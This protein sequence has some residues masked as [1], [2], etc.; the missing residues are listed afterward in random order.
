MDNPNNKAG[1]PISD[2]VSDEDLLSLAEAA[3]LTPYSQEYISLLARKG[4]LRAW[5]KG[6][7]W[8]TSKLAV[9]EYLN[10]QAQ[11]AKQE[12]LRKAKFEQ[13]SSK[14]QV[15]I[16][17]QAV[18]SLSKDLINP[19]DKSTGPKISEI[20]KPS[21]SEQAVNE[22]ASKI[23]ELSTTLRPLLDQ[24]LLGP[25]PE[26][27]QP[28]KETII[29]KD[30][31]LVTPEPRS[32]VKLVELKHRPW[33][34]Y[35]LAGVIL[36]VVLGTITGGIAN[37][38]PARLLASLK[39][40]WTIDG[41]RAGTAANEVLILNEAGNISIKG[42][43][44]TGG[45][46]RS[47][48]RDGIMP[49]VVDSTTKVENLNA[50]TVDGFSSEQFTLAF[51][52]KNGAVTT[53]DVQL[54]GDVEV[55]GNLEVK[56]AVKLTDALLVDGGLGVWGDAIFHD[57]LAVEGGVK[58]GQ[59]LEVAGPLAA[60]GGIDTQNKDISLGT[61]T[62]HTENRSVVENLNA[63][64]LQ[65][66]SLA[67]MTLDLV[68]DNGAITDNA[69][70]I[71]GLNVSGAS[72]F[73]GPATFTSAAQFAG[74]LTSLGFTQLLGPTVLGNIQQLTV[75]G[76]TN[77]HDTSI[78]G[79]L[80]VSGTGIFNSVGVSGLIG[81]NTLSSQQLSVAHDETFGTTANDDM[82]VNSTATLT[83]RLTLK[84]QWS[85]MAI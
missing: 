83:G 64:L 60:R 81:T 32:V 48:A 14:E 19:V 68:T 70:G 55:G 38:A 69:V 1:F 11:G 10:S 43:I 12:Y 3:K 80:N 36:L 28:I 4:K 27:S 39:N 61:G 66:K 75:N 62:I 49:I 22:L 79:S 57:D 41:H 5:K 72:S 78:Q 74:G 31:N 16:P 18:S 73:N 33:F 8:F 29:V 7:N 25:K 84:N 85:W 26:V 34:L 15:L 77:L 76:Q 58:V 63:E 44:E 59:T 23:G 24:T 35:G 13:V 21:V 42:H 67:D 82:I 9:E 30:I 20:S 47:F 71:G 37:D 54:K 51:I 53:D 56:G 65:G 40:A 2:V 17:D 6:R 50:D 52:T 46:L 45:Q